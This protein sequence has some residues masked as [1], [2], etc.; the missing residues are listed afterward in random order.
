M[1]VPILSTTYISKARQC[2]C[3]VVAIG[4]GDHKILLDPFQYSFGLLGSFLHWLRFILNVLN[5]LY[6][7]VL[8]NGMWCASRLKPGATITLN[9]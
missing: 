2:L 4:I 7:T 1:T 6:L 8:Y 9:L 5:T 3:H